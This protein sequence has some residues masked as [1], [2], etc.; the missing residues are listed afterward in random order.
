MSS[1]L[2]GFSGSR[3]LPAAFVP[4]VAGAVQQARRLG[5]GLAVGCASG[6]DQYVRH[7]H[8]ARVFYAQEFM[9]PGVSFRAALARRSAAL[10]AAVAA[11]G[12]PAQFVVFV[13]VPCPRG[14]AP[15][16][17][18]SRCFAGFG[19]GSWGTAALAVGSGLPVSVFW[20][21]A[22][23]P[24]LPAWAGSWGASPAFPGAFLFSPAVVQPALW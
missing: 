3:S 10:V 1:A 15:S 13:S 2:C 6:A 9:A 7:A 18:P 5:L 20:C 17:S 23:A 22:G 19:S 14:L 4:L 11:S 12:P 21:G 8:P 24:A 16:P